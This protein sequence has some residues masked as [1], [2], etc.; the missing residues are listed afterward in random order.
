MADVLDPK[1]LREAFNKGERL[2]LLNPPAPPHTDTV[3][4]E[5]KTVTTI[6]DALKG[7]NIKKVVAESTY[8]AQP[9]EGIGDLSVL[10]EME[11]R[12]HRLGIPGSI[13]R[14][15][16][17]M[18]NWD[19][20]LATAKNEG[21][22]YSFYPADFKLPMVAPEDIGKTAADLLMEPIEMTGLHHVE[23]PEEYS[24][25]D[26]ADA[27]ARSLGQPVKVVEITRDRWIPVLKSMG[28]SEKAAAS[29]AAMTKATL[30][31]PYKREDP[32]RG[33]ITLQDY[34][35]ALSNPSATRPPSQAKSQPL[36]R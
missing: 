31:V 24:A 2:F 10:Y 34:I 4:Q 3:T 16:Y 28:F 17:Y 21:V 23:G 14:G 27:F 29:M 8:G 20:S 13:I 1:Q 5:K 15:A 7:S 9:G 25:N 33:I 32:V 36:A 19:M 11:Q 6:L 35:G 22:V 30:E 12:L 26:V 18:S